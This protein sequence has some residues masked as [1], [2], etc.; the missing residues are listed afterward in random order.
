MSACY[1]FFRADNE[2]LRRL[3]PCPRRSVGRARPRSASSNANGVMAPASVRYQRTGGV[4]RPWSVS[5]EHRTPTPEP[6]VSVRSVCHP[7]KAGRL[8]TTKSGVTQ[9]VVVGHLH[10]AP[11]AAIN[12]VTAP[13]YSGQSTVW[14]PRNGFG[15]ANIV[16]HLW[17]NTVNFLFLWRICSTST[18]SA[19]LAATLYLPGVRGADVDH[20]WTRAHQ[21]G[22]QPASSTMRAERPPTLPASSGEVLPMVTGDGRPSHARPAGT[23]AKPAC[24][25]SSASNTRDETAISKGRLVC[26]HAFAANNCDLGSGDGSADHPPERSTQPAGL[27][28][29]A[30]VADQRQPTQKGRRATS[31]CSKPPPREGAVKPGA[32]ATRRARM[33]IASQCFSAYRHSGPPSSCRTRR[34]ATGRGW[35]S[36]PGDGRRAGLSWL[37]TRITGNGRR[38]LEQNRVCGGNGPSEAST[39]AQHP[40][41][42]DSPR[43]PRH[44]PVPGAPGAYDIDY[45]ATVPSGDGGARRCSWPGFPLQI[46]RV[47]HPF[48]AAH[49]VHAAPRLAATWRQPGWS[50]RGRRARRWQRRHDGD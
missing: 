12:C 30:A 4:S 29:D 28:V 21:L 40:S 44:R 17:L 34:S 43:P 49:R 25:R 33:R 22:I 37:T 27:C 6:R 5:V 41:T 24:R 45:G 13:M 14:P 8:E 39:S 31:A 2:V 46:A 42:M 50:C 9:P 11:W 10:H 3:I 32:V 35:Q 36:R 47:H 20:E 38:D 18:A 1:R 16:C 15:S 26:V 23:D 7:I 19:V 48:L